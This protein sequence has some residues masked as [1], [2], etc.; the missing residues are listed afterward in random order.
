MET[1]KESIE[2]RMFWLKIEELT[3]LLKKNHKEIVSS[4]RNNNREYNTKE[5][6]DV[7]LLRLQLENLGYKLGEIIR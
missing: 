1:E 4:I 7:E 6:K 2:E 5:S 3:L